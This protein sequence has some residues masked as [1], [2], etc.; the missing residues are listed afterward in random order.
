MGTPQIAMTAGADTNLDTPPSSVYETFDTSQTKPVLTSIS[1]R[2][3]LSPYSPLWF[4]HQRMVRLR[5][6]APAEPYCGLAFTALQARGFGKIGRPKI[7]VKEIPRAKS[8]RMSP[9]LAQTSR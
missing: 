5:L 3:P 4:I 1:S 8:V 7:I 6:Q 9:N 2:L